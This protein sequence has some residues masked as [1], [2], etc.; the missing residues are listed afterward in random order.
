MGTTLGVVELLPPNQT[1][2]SGPM[3]GMARRKF[4]GKSLVEWVVR[5]MSD[6]EQIRHLFILTPD[7]EACHTLAECAPPDVAI[8]FS[9]A[10]DA[11]GRLADFCRQHRCEG[12]VRLSVAQPFIDPALV[13]RLVA[14]AQGS[15]YAAYHG[16]QER[17]PNGSSV[18]VFAEYYS[19]AALI[20]AERTARG[21]ERN[22]PGRFMECH[23]ELFMLK[24]LPVPSQLD[25]DD[26]R[27]VIETE[28]D[29]EHVQII[30]DALGPECLDW[31]FIA[32]LLDRHPGIRERMA[33][34]NRE[35]MV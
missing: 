13:D 7:T 1:N 12:I 9:P 27:L 10:T 30:F 35:A 26:L 31:Q 22:E 28:E 25:R 32:N 5:R 34:R 15:D 17:C 19:S 2:I 16:G 4:A 33:E 20:T 14:S 24:F 3:F 23:P 21:A 8:H 11:L 29:W 6:A 18:G